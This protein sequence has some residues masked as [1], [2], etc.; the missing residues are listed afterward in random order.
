M[1]YINKIYEGDETMNDLLLFLNQINE[2]K[3]P[4]TTTFCQDFIDVLKWSNN[5]SVDCNVARDFLKSNSRYTSEEDLEVFM[6]DL[7][8]QYV[9]INSEEHRKQFQ[10]LINAYLLTLFG[11]INMQSVRELMNCGFK[12]YPVSFTENGPIIGI[13]TEPGNIIIQPLQ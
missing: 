12:C 7:H 8:T 5:T 11:K 1:Y 2:R 10:K 6:R 13:I 3:I 4:V 9:F